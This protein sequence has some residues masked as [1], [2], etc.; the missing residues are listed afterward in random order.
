M[1]TSNQ[2]QQF[3]NEEFGNIRV[4]EID[5]QPWF[6]G[7]DVALA[8]GYSNTKD[9]LH[10]HIDTEDR[11]IIQRSQIATFEIPPRGLSFINESGL[12]SLILSSKL[13]AARRFKRWVT[14]EVLPTIRKHRAYAT[15]NTLDELLRSPQF[16]RRLIKKLEAERDKSTTLEVENAALEELATEM[17]PKALYCDAV[18]Q[19]TN[20]F[21]VSVIAKDYGMGAASFN[22]LLHD[23]G[24]QFRAGGTWL[25]YAKYAHLG[26]TRTTTY[27]VDERIAAIHTRWT[28]K[29]RMFLYEFLKAHGILPLGEYHCDEPLPA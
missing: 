5:G 9:V 26:Y 17:A 18:L 11:T 29:G 2:I 8:L 7:K 6:A 1:K 25:L 28:Q 16:A 4:I 27:S 3:H 20:L 24:I 19:S 23:Y 14:S 12:Y 13:P 21:P 22:A 15:S 10:K